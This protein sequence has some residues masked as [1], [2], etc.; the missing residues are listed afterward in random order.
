MYAIE[1]IAGEMTFG[2]FGGG[3]AGYL[4]VSLMCVVFESRKGTS[5]CSPSPCDYPETLCGRPSECW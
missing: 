3:N 5:L 1:L 4:D 2:L